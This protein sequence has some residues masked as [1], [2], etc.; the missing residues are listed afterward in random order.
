MTTHAIHRHDNDSY[1]ANVF[2]RILPA[3][4]WELREELAAAVH[5]ETRSRMRQTLTEHRRRNPG[6]PLP[7]SGLVC[8]AG[9][10]H[11]AFWA[12]DCP[13][14]GAG[15]HRKLLPD[16]EPNRQLADEVWV[17]CPA[18]RA[19]YAELTTQELPTQS[20]RAVPRAPERPP[21]R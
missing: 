19:V 15:G 4:R 5:A 8:D 1:L 21:G 14:C 6:E 17:T 2:R 10:V 7:V 20:H 16:P 9:H 3:A 13:V 11:L 18:C 12:D